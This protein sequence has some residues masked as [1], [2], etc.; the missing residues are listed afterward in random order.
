MEKAIVLTTGGLHSTTALAIAASKNYELYALTID[1]GQ[2]RF[3]LNATNDIAKQ[4][5]VKEH[6]I[7]TFNID[8]ILPEGDTEI[9]SRNSLFLS[10]ALSWAQVVQAEHLYIGIS[11]IDFGDKPDCRKECVHTFE[12]LANVVMRKDDDNMHVNV[13]SPLMLATFP[14]IIKRGMSM[15]VDYAKTYSCEKLDDKGSACGTCRSCAI[16]RSGFKQAH[17]PDPTRYIS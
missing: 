17:V 10:F 2:P 6:K 4:F 13:W 7:V 5:K 3:K 16:R 15:G 12:G 9:P 1:H 14:D 8:A 11:E